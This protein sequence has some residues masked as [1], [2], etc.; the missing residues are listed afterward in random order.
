MITRAI[1]GTI[2]HSV[3][4]VIDNNS[5]QSTKVFVDGTLVGS[6]Q[7]HFAPKLKGGVFVLNQYQSTGVFK[8]FRLEPCDSFDSKGTCIEGNGRKYQKNLVSSNSCRNLFWRHAFI[9]KKV[10]RPPSCT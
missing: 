1:E 9:T 3:K 4:L 10:R 7:E 2:Y 5:V 6:F 8:N